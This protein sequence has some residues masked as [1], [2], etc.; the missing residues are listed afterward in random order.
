[1]LEGAGGFYVGGSFGAQTAAVRGILGSRNQQQLRAWDRLLAEA[2]R[3]PGVAVYSQ[4]F[5][6][7]ARRHRARQVVESFGD[8]PVD[9][10]VTVRD[11][12]SAMPA[13]WQS[14]VRNRGTDDWPRYVRRLLDMDEEGPEIS[15]AVRS[16]RRAQDAPL[17][18]RRW[19]RAGA[20]AVI[21]V[22]VP[23]AGSP[24]TEL[25]RRFCA[26]ARIP[27]EDP[28]E[29]A[30]KS[31]ESLGYASCEV[32]RR[33]NTHVAALERDE[34]RRVRRVVLDA[35]LPLR[36]DEG[37]PELDAEGAAFAR[38]LNERIAEAVDEG[39]Y[40]LVGSLAELPVAEDPRRPRHIR[41]PDLE[42]VSRA[43]ATAWAAC[44]PGAQLPAGDPDHL[45]V[46]LA[47][48]L[49]GHVGGA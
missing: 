48:R 41:G 35:L 49:V 37:R 34:Y 6:G 38:E 16:F 13:Q 15:K 1:V 43:L 3:R 33:V 22:T 20:A 36:G 27:A 40:G 18:L 42:H 32:L 31:N 8:T 21:V 25:W 4:E 44:G 45:A 24:P 19:A 11:Q 10:V 39:G 29:A 9:V 5:L 30:A 12:H 14:F 28:P 23:P 2:R 46:L 26:A 7:F 47:R 17:M